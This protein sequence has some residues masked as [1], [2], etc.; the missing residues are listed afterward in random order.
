MCDV[1]VIDAKVVK[2]TKQLSQFTRRFVTACL[3][4]QLDLPAEAETMHQAPEPEALARWNFEKGKKD[5]NNVATNGLH[6]VDEHAPQKKDQVRLVGSV[7][8]HSS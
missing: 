6:L 4:Q 1:V 8:G 2:T 3:T 5:K 7:A